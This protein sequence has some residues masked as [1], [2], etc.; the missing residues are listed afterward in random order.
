LKPRA[1]ATKSV[2]ARNSEAQKRS[3]QPERL[4][5]F[6]DSLD[7]LAAGLRAEPCDVVFNLAERFRDE[8]ALD[9]TVASSWRFISRLPS[10]LKQTTVRSGFESAAPIAAGRPKPIVPRPPEVRNWRG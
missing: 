2:F 8:S 9:Y 6:R 5:A 10:P 4:L 1:I 7:Q 3:P